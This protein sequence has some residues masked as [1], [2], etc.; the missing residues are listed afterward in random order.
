MQSN[1]TQCTPYSTKKK[2]IKILDRIFSLCFVVIIQPLTIATDDIITV[3]DDVSLADREPAAGATPPKRDPFLSF[4]H[5]FSPKSARVGGR[6]ALPMG[7][8]GPATDVT[9]ARDDVIHII[10]IMLSSEL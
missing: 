4:S 7:N 10:C 2:Q 3:I 8:P 1:Y 6:C 5:T 9:A